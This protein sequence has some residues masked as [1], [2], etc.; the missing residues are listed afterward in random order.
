MINIENVTKKYGSYTAIENVSLDIDEYSIFGLIGYNGSGKT[1]LLKTAA[2]I[3]K[4]E[5]GAVKMGGEDVYDNKDIRKDMFYLSDDLYTPITYSMIKMALFYSGYYPSFD[6]NKFLEIS[7]LLGLDVNKNLRGFSKGMR[8]QAQIVIALSCMPK[9][10]LLDE[11]FDGVDPI[12][13]T[14][15]KDLLM[16]YMAATGCSVIISSHNMAEISSICDDIAILSDKS[17]KFRSKTDDLSNHYLRVQA[18]FSNPVT[19]SDFDGLDLREIS[20]SDRMMSAVIAGDV[21]NTLSALKQK[22]VT[23]IKTAAL[24]LEEIF[25]LETAE[26]EGMKDDISKIFEK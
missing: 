2:G 9:Y 1:T 19:K 25:I 18:L 16:E 6:K 21:K 8:R 26:M 14:V 10:L 15:V 7:K 23:D 13:R 5:T 12:K 4:P 20:I 24:T 22:Q 3:Y 17:V 11:S